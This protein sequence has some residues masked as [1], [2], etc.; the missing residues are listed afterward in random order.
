M[1]TVYKHI[2]E[3]TAPEHRFLITSHKT[4]VLD[5][6]NV[7]SFTIYIKLTLTIAKGEYSTKQVYVTN[8]IVM[9]I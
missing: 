1:I 4:K 6:A 5:E 2:T 3:I 8:K 9:N 7:D